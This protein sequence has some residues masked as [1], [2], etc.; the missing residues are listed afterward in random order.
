M[1]VVYTGAIGIVVGLGDQ[2]DLVTRSMMGITG[3]MIWLRGVRSLLTNSPDP[4]SRR[5]LVRLQMP[6][7]FHPKP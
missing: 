7:M 4:L 3:V 2:G 1:G 5:S 6:R